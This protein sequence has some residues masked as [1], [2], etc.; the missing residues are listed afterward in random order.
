MGLFLRKNHLLIK[1]FGLSFS[2]KLG[3]GSYIISIAKTA[4]SKIGVLI[5]CMEFLSP[6][7]ALHLYKSTIWPGME[8]CSHV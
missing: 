2:S 6:E 8:Y 4:P 3:W 5:H 7:F 1:M